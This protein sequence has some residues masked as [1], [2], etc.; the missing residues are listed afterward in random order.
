TIELIE[1]ALKVPDRFALKHIIVTGARRRF[2]EQLVIALQPRPLT[3]D[4]RNAT[5][6][7]VVSPLVSVARALP[8]FTRKTTTFLSP[9]A[10]SVRDCLLEAREPDG[11][12]FAAL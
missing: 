5:V 12:L 7:Q 11:L 8:E 10:A 9:H 2:L 1:R 4:A 6:L 3:A